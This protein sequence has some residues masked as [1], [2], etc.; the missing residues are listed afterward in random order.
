MRHGIQFLLVF[1]LIFHSFALLEFSNV[2]EVRYSW[3]A[4]CAVE[5]NT[6]SS[7][8]TVFSSRF[9]QLFMLLFRR[10]WHGGCSKVRAARAARLFFFI[11]PIKFFVYGV[12]ADDTEAPLRLQQQQREHHKFTYFMTKSNHLCTHPAHVRFLFN[13]SHTSAVLCQT[14]KKYDQIRNSAEDMITRH[15]SYFSR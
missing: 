14:T 11:Q 13:H 3:N 5:V 2:S 9:R 6:E 10:G 8:F 1:N 15:V 4:R 7:R 12:A